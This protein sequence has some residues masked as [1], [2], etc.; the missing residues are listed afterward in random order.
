LAFFEGSGRVLLGS[1]T[2]KRTKASLQGRGIFIPGPD[3]LKEQR[4]REG[5]NFAAKIEFTKG[6]NQF[7]RVMA[8][9][10]FAMLE[11]TNADKDPHAAS[12][13]AWLLGKFSN[14]TVLTD[15]RGGCQAPGLVGEKG[16]RRF[17]KRVEFFVG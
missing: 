8:D 12:C 15:L 17:P 10:C 11:A 6:C 5:P 14:L 1:S 9:A 4:S 13:L 16:L 7:H 2:Q 3:P